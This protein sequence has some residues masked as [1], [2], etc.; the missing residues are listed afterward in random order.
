MPRVFKPRPVKYALPTLIALALVA[1]FSQS[2]HYALVSHSV[3]SEHGEMVHGRGHLDVDPS[4]GKP[5][6]V[7]G[8]GKASVKAGEHHDGDAHDH[9]PVMNRPRERIALPPVDVVNVVPLPPDVAMTF[10]RAESPV[11]ADPLFNAPKSSP[12]V[13]NA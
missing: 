1:Q 9:C 10:D 7:K 2:A 6:S 5:G 11:G 12:P 4:R 3:C 13:E 8:D